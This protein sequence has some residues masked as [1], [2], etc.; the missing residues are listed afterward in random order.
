MM[1]EEHV[2][3][4]TSLIFI[5]VRS[6]SIWLVGSIMSSN[7]WTLWTVARL[8]NAHK[9]KVKINAHVSSPNVDLLLF[10]TGQ[11]L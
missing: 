4:L 8:C 11:H 10:K 1:V 9:Y 5:M 2:K 7:D 3:A 6:C